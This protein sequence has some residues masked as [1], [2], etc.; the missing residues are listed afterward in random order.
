MGRNLLC[1]PVSFHQ[2]LVYWYDMYKHITIIRISLYTCF[3]V[4]R[5]WRKISSLYIRFWVPVN[6]GHRMILTKNVTRQDFRKV[7]RSVRLF[8]HAAQGHWLQSNVLGSFFYLFCFP[9][10]YFGFHGYEFVVKFYSYFQSLKFLF[11]LSFNLTL[12]TS[13]RLHFSLS[14]TWLYFSE[15]FISKIN[16][17]H[18]LSFSHRY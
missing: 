8:C 17:L 9:R 5:K 7:M 3:H 1:F 14:T 10:L 12:F 16:Y 18:I 11:Q 15:R 6:F 4:G 2:R 13:L